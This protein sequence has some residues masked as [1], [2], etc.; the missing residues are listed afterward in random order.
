MR[1]LRYEIR[2]GS[3]GAGRY[4]GGDGIR[5]DFQLLT[6][7]TVGLLSDRRRF[8]P[9]G[10]HG[11]ESGLAGESILMTSAGARPLGSK[12]HIRVS[13]G[14]VISVRTPGG[15]GYGRRAGRNT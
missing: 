3:G 1:I 4:R 12:F 8:R 9:Y 2:R 14:D 11:G 7:A 5:R 15:G 10:L 13:A 6:D